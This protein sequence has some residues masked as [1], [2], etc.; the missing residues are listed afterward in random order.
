MPLRVRMCVRPAHHHL[1]RA[2]RAAGFFFFH[3][4][5]RPAS[6]LAFPI[7]QL[8][9]RRGSLLS[10]AALLFWGGI[11]IKLNFA[12]LEQSHITFLSDLLNE[13]TIISAL[14]SEIMDYAAWLDAYQTH[15]KN[16]TD[17]AHFI[18]FSDETPVGW[19][20]LNGLDDNDVVW[21]S[22]LVISE[23][24]QGKEYGC[25]A[26]AFSEAIAKERGFCTMGIHTTCDNFSAITLYLSCKY[27]IT[28][29][30]KCTTGDGTN[31]MGY[32]F[33]KEI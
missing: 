26:V 16:D 23:Q 3:F 30:S 27:K 21:I 18:I 8:H 32:T 22:M 25:Q 6:A 9:L 13:P 20:K 12:K 31:H 11:T 2:I 17:E 29:Y 28:D 4:N 15:W 1:R 14:H 24:H 7:V 10:L 5:K 19:L 33:K